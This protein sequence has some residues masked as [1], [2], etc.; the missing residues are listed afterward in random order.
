MM[1]VFGTRPTEVAGVLG[2]VLGRYTG[3]VGLNLNF[4]LL[5]I[6]LAATIND[7]PATGAAW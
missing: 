4:G 7:M 3:F 1:V 5:G 2:A 6:I